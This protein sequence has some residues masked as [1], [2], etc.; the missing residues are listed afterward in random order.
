[1]VASSIKV[2]VIIII[3]DGGGGTH[4]ARAASV[5]MKKAK[6]TREQSEF[7]VCG[8]TRTRTYGDCRN[9]QKKTK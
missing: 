5:D 2:V 9:K 3:I 6:T 4:A 7:C 1:V 8:T